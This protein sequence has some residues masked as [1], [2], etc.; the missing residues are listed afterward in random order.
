MNLHS[1]PPLSYRNRSVQAT[2]PSSP[3]LPQVSSSFKV[4]SGPN[5]WLFALAFLVAAEFSSFSCGPWFA[6]FSA[7]LLFSASGGSSNN[8][9]IHRAVLPRSPEPAQSPCRDKKRLHQPV[10]KDPTIPRGHPDV[11]SQQKRALR[12]RESRQLPRPGSREWRTGYY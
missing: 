10:E 8:N 4:R 6:C 12:R 1:Q 5:A 11:W 3:V 9:H 2:I 7:A